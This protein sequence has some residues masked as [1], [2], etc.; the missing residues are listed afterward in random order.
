MKVAKIFILI[1]T[2]IFIFSILAYGDEEGKAIR[3]IKFLM[4]KG[5]YENALV[6]ANFYLEREPKSLRVRKLKI[7]ILVELSQFDNALKDYEIFIRYS[8]A[9]TENI[10][11]LSQ[12]LVPYLKALKNYSLTPTQKRKLYSMLCEIKDGETIREL[13]EIYSFSPDRTFK[14][15]AASLLSQLGKKG[16][17]AYLKKAAKFTDLTKEEKLYIIF[18]FSGRE[19]ETLRKTLLFMLKREKDKEVIAYIYWALTKLGEDHRK[20]LRTMLNEVGDRIK[21]TVLFLLGEL[22]D[23]RFTLDKKV[24]DELCLPSLYWAQYRKGNV[25]AINN[26]RKLISSSNKE[27]SLLSIFYIGLIGDKISIPILRHKIVESQDMDIKIASISSI[28]RIIRKDRINTDI[29]IKVGFS[30]TL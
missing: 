22:K 17:I 19:S 10:K 12:I 3:E 4:K 26:L 21:G 25:S 1:F 27:V 9:K 8:K 16:Y 23:S 5:L 14:I 28:I 18:A 24:E 29:R 13:K 6:R 20:E 11:I 2:F 7:D 15:W 30:I